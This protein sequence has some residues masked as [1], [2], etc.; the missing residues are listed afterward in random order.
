MEKYAVLQVD[1]DSTTCRT[2]GRKLQR[3]G[4]TLLCPTHGS[5]PLEKVING[6][7]KEEARE[8]AQGSRD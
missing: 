2:C 5:A 6:S 1:S 4:S 3:F 7:T 8:E